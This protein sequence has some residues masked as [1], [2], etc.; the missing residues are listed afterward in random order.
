MFSNTQWLIVPQVQNADDNQ[1]PPEVDAMLVFILQENRVV[2]VN[3]EVGFTPANMKALC[4]VGN[5][6]KTGSGAGYIGHKG[7]GFKSVFRVCFIIKLIK[8]F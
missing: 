5:S 8:C 6:T 1:Y 3:N 2:V 7:I 4:D